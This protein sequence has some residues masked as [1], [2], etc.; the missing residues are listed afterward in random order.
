MSV[1]IEVSV[2][3]LTDSKRNLFISVPGEIIPD[4]EFYDFESKYISDGS[5]LIVPAGQTT[6][7]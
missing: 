1:E 2:L 5:K 7:N 3:E 6:T 4:R